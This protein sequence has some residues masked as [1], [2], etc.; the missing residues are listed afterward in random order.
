M[1]GG[2]MPSTPKITTFGYSALL[3][4]LH[5]AANRHLDISDVPDDLAERPRIPRSRPEIVIDFFHAIGGLREHTLHR[6]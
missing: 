3:F 4:A 2:S 1:A 6:E 5:G